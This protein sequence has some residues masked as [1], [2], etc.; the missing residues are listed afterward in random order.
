[1]GFTKRNTFYEMGLNS[2]SELIFLHSIKSLLKNRQY[3]SLP[4][5][6]KLLSQKHHSD[7]KMV[8]LYTYYHQ[9]KYYSLSEEKRVV[10]LEERINNDNPTRFTELFNWAILEFGEVATTK[11]EHSLN[12]LKKFPIFHED[13]QLTYLKLK[14]NTQHFDRTERYIRATQSQNQKIRYWGLKH[15]SL[16]NNKR[17][18]KYLT[19][20]LDQ[21]NLHSGHLEFANIKDTLQEH[22]LKFPSLYKNLSKNDL[23]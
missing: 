21:N 3:S 2:D 1:M 23:D 13:L 19:L 7:Q 4:I 22:K 6:E 9:L 10:Y 16:Y 20:L 12:R 14:L 5:I 18:S 8:L 15:L 17:V 11:N